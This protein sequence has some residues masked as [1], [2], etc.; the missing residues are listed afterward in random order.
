MEN[1]AMSA[2]TRLHDNATNVYGLLCACG[3]RPCDYRAT[4]KRDELAPPHGL[5]PQAEDYSIAL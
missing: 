3:K 4:D 5:R 1:T 2:A